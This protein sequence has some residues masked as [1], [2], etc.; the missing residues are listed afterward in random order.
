MTTLASFDGVL[1]TVP[2]LEELQ[3]FDL[4]DRGLSPASAIAWLQDNG[5]LTTAVYYPATQTIGFPYEYMAL[6]GGQ[7]ELV[8]RVGA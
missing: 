7:W 8:R 5:Y 6:V 1:H 4:L 2:T 3:M